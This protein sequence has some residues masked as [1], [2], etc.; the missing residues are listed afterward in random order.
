MKALQI[1]DWKLAVNDRG[2]FP[3]FENFNSA[4]PI[5]SN[6]AGGVQKFIIFFAAPMNSRMREAIVDVSIYQCMF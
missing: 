5:Q 1:Y 6:A 4:S 3:Y 2:I